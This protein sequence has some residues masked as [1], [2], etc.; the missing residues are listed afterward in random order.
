MNAPLTLFDKPWGAHA[1]GIGASKVAKGLTTQP[2]CERKPKRMRIIVNGYL[3]PG[4]AAKDLVLAIIAR[5]SADGATGHAVEF[6]GSAIRALSMEGRLTLCNMSIEAGAR[7]GMI[8][9]DETTF[10]Y[11][12]VRPYPPKGAAFEQALQPWS[13]LHTDD[14]AEFDREVEL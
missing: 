5:I 14:R 2:L 12:K 8:A 9:P 10:E 3:G 6:G 1:C 11:V 4:I 13:R 7:S